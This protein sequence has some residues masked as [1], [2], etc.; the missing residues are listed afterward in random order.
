[1][2]SLVSA[3]LSNLVNNGPAVLLW[4]TVAQACP[5]RSRVGLAGPGDVEHVC[6]NF[7]VL[8]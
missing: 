6:R 7:T 2:L 8:G 1:L 4:N 3:A 5:R